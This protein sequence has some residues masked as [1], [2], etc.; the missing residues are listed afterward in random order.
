MTNFIKQMILSRKK[1]LQ[2]QMG[3]SFL[4]ISA[5]ESVHPALQCGEPGWDFPG[6]I[7]RRISARAILE[8]IAFEYAYYLQILKDLLP[9]LHFVEARVVGGGARSTTW[10]QI[11]A[12]VPNIPYQRLRR[13]EFG[14]WGAAMI[15]GKAVGLI[16]DLA[17]YAEKSAAVKGKPIL[18]DPGY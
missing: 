9:E 11:K 6:V 5:A 3:Y 10:N 1:L 14:T 2:G 16:N 18:P 8:S 13:N 4:R 17:E 7:P 12:N 15:A